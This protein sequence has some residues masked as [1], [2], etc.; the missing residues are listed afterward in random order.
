MAGIAS[1]LP[2]T[3]YRCA[4]GTHFPA[5]RKYVDPGLVVAKVEVADPGIRRE[6]RPHFGDAGGNAQ[7]IAFQESSVAAKKPWFVGND[8][9]RQAGNLARDHVAN[10]MVVVDARALFSL[11]CVRR[12]PKQR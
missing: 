10:L 5:S 8:E 3:R 12:H 2:L 1:M 7:V 4:V 6:H 11:Q 9:N